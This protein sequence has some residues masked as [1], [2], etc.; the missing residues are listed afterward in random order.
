MTTTDKKPVRRT[1]HTQKPT[2]RKTTRSVSGIIDAMN[3]DLDKVIGPRQ[4]TSGVVYLSWGSLSLD[5]ALGGGVPY[6]RLTEIYGGESCGKTT[7]VSQALVEV[8]KTDGVGVLIETE[9]SFDPVYARRLGLD[10]DKLIVR[11][12]DVIEDV[13]VAIDTLVTAWKS[14]CDDTTPMLIVW[15][16]V[17]GTPPRAEI[18]GEFDS[19]H[20]AVAACRISQSLRMIMGKIK[21]SRIA[22]VFTNQV[23]EN[24]G[25]MFGAKLRTYG[26]RA[27]KF[28]ASH[29]IDLRR[30][31]KTQSKTGDV[32]S[33]SVEAK[34][35]KNKTALP[36]R[37]AEFDIV[38]GRGVCPATEA[39]SLGE[40]YG[41]VIRKGAWFTLGDERIG[42]GRENAVKTLI[43]SPE[44][45][46]GLVDEIKKNIEAEQS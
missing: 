6:G 12:P 19:D 22:I 21:N 27:I 20:M 45:L 39:L 42:Q 23:R 37:K 17:A 7:L 30:T 13:F 38:F 24:I 18:D 25:V 34:V 41:L 5:R 28:H 3:S 33:I 2:P 32:I 11:Q 14:K 46:D 44:L 35:Q 15:D 29:R 9:G 31:G 26:G 8:Q 4:E 16:S 43:D 10:M 36:F 40:K 1:R